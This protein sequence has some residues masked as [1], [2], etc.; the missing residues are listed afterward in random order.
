MDWLISFWSE[1]TNFIAEYGLLTVAP[2]VLITSAGIPLPVPSDLLVMLMGAQARDGRHPL[3]LAWLL[4]SAC[5][6][7]GSTALYEFARW[8]GL[9]G[10]TEVAQYGRYVGLSERR[11]MDAKTYLQAGGQ[12]AIVIARFVP[13]LKLAVVIACGVLRIPRRT[14]LPAIGS[15]PWH[16]WARYWR[17]AI[18]SGNQ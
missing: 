4:L 16:T 9:G 6:F 11:L 15:P 7:V 3:W 10:L 12:R 18:C 2:I 1:L 13:A 14:Y 8:I 5:T 17:W